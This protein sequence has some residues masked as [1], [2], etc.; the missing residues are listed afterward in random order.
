MIKIDF[1]GLKEL[2]IIGKILVLVNAKYNMDLTTAKIPL[3]DLK[4]M[5]FFQQALPLVYFSFQKAR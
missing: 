2:K 4:H 3:D 5:S 1:L